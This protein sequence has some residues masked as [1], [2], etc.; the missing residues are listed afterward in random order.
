M[1]DCIHAFALLQTCII[2]EYM[3]IC[4][5]ATVKELKNPCVV[6]CVEII[7]CAGNLH[8]ETVTSTSTLYKKMVYVLWNLFLKI[9][10]CR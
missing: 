4:T 9:P 10:N 1:N 8:P 2:Y 5:N 3:H 7:M 6:Q